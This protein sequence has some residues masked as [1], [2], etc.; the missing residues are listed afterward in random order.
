MSE[1]L[2]QLV[3]KRKRLGQKPKGE[4]TLV[5]FGVALLVAVVG[6]AQLRASAERSSLA[7]FHA[8]DDLDREIVREV[9]YRSVVLLHSPQLVFRHWSQATVSGCRGCAC[10]SMMI[11]SRV[12]SAG[13]AAASSTVRPSSAAGNAPS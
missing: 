3:P 6:L 12:V 7:G 11:A 8:T 10:P 13:S 2:K 1:R 4:P 5:A 9:P